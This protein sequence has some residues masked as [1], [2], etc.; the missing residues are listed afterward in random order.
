VSL[1]RVIAVADIDVKVASPQVF[2]AIVERIAKA[3]ADE[4]AVHFQIDVSL[5]YGL[6]ASLVTLWA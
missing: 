3:A 4:Q 6:L 1:L 2:L 5:L